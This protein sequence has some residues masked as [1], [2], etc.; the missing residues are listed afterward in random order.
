MSP[1]LQHGKLLI[2]FMLWILI[3]FT[4]PA[5]MAQV[6]YKKAGLKNTSLHYEI[7]GEGTPLILIHGS[8]ADL[9]Y[10]EFQT[11]KLS[12]HYQ[13][14]TYSRRYNYPNTNKMNANHSALV[15][16]QDLLELMNLLKIEQAHILGHSYG[17]YTALIFASNHPERVKKLILAEAPLMRWL[18]EIPGGEG[19]MEDFMKEV[20][21]PIAEAFNESEEAGLEFTSQW[22]YDTSFDNISAEWQVFLIDNAME[23]K[24]LTFSDDAFPY[25]DPDKLKTLRLPV[26]LLSGEKNQG[27]FFEL[28]ERRLTKLLP[29]I[30]QSVIKNAGHEMFLDNPPDTNA[31]ILNFLKD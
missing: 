19:V 6:I 14:I 9:R 22:Y 13:V 21:I 12:Y 17:A 16:A 10:W 20:W 25:V 29:D 31:A 1:S 8:L 4:S 3:I 28:I 5:I 7:A 18:P 15:E 23:W 27:R 2:K 24:A 11:P 26:L 30:H